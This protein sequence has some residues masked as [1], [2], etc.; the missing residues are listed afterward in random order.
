MSVPFGYRPLRQWATRHWTFPRKL[1]DLTGEAGVETML[2]CGTA[3]QQD[4][5]FIHTSC[6][7][8]VF[9]FIIIVFSDLGVLSALCSCTTCVPRTL[10]GHYEVS[11]SLELELQLGPTI[12]V[13]AIKLGSLAEQ[14]S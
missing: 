2:M 11:D 3:P 7:C 6:V 10:G 12:W 4:C 13:L 14:S 5:L 9:F 1:S 8:V